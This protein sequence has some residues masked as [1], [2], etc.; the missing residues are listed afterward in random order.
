MSMTDAQ[1]LADLLSPPSASDE[2]RL[3]DQLWLRTVFAEQRRRVR[4]DERTA[5][6][7]RADRLLEALDPC[8][9]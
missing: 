9:Q 6:E 2:Q 5:F 8:R 3:L 7:I 1:L 4:Y